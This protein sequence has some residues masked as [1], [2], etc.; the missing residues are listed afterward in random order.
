M[1]LVGQKY[2]ISTDD[3]KGIPV[4]GLVI[5]ISHFPLPFR[6]FLTKQSDPRLESAS[7]R[8][9]DFGRLNKVNGPTLWEI[10][11]DCLSFKLKFPESLRVCS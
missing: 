7:F 4:F 6:L 3:T 10:R 5:N 11:K 8:I 9:S 1:I 2:W